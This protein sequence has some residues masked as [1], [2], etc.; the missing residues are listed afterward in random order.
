MPKLDLRVYK[1]E[2]RASMR[3]I[4][5]E[6]PEPLRREKDR[7][8]YE[9]LV[10]LPQYKQA[11]TI[12]TYVSSSVEVDTRRFL[13]RALDDGKR[14]AVP[15]CVPGTHNMEMFY[16]N[17]MDELESGSYGILEPS[18]KAQKCLKWR[19]SMC[20]VP[21]FCNDRQGYRLGYGGGYYD[22]F[23]SRY[24]GITVGINYSECVR[25][26]I[27]HGRYDVPLDLLLTERELLAFSKKDQKP[28]T[29]RPKTQ[30]TQGQAPKKSFRPRRPQRTAKTAKKEN[31]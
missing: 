17:S 23:L 12:I 30:E 11:H 19:G 2:L 6:M 24:S 3:R 26:S 25:D 21:A 13:Q 4:R 14:V 7:L 1:K 10:R 16:I 28:Q 5:Q 15:R 27:C 9:R 8:I 29:S 22:R 18:P 20:V 31:I